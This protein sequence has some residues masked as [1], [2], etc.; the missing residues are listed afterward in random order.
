MA[1][2]RGKIVSGTRLVESVLA[3]E[4]GVSRTPIREALHKLDLEELVYS[5]PRVGYIVNDMTEEIRALGPFNR[6]DGGK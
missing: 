1:I 4:M 3:V 6:S 2:L 5:M